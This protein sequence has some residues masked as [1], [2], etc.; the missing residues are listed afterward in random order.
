MSFREEKAIGDF[1]KKKG[2]NALGMAAVGMA[3][4]GKGYSSY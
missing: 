3:S 2:Q 1:W 4:F